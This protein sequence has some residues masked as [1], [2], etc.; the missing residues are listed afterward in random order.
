MIATLVD[1]DAATMSPKQLLINITVSLPAGGIDA[2]PWP[3]QFVASRVDLI[4]D[5]SGS[6][7]VDTIENDS[8]DVEPEKD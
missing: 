4:D 2:L 6:L 8:D 1:F 5:D 3:T 7:V